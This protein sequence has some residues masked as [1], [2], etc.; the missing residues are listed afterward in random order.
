LYSFGFAYGSA[1]GIQDKK[2]GQLSNPGWY[3]IRG[4]TS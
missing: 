2:H 4:Q 1:S 3:I